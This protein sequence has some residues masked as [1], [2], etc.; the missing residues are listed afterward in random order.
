MLKKPNIQ[1]VKIPTERPLSRPKNFP[2][3]PILYLEL[4]E[5]KAKINPIL[6]NQ[7]YVPKNLPP[8]APLPVI[9]ER[10]EYED[11]KERE[12]YPNL[13]SPP[14]KSGSPSPSP[15]S[16]SSPSSRHSRNSRNSSGNSRHS[17]GRSR[18]SRDSSK[19]SGSPVDK[20]SSRE[21]PSRS[22]DDDDDLSSRM[23]ELM[24]EE[25]RDR[26]DRNDR[27]DRHDRHDRHDKHDK[28]EKREYK[29]ESPVFNYDESTMGSSNILPPRLSEISG[30]NYVK[31]KV[32]EELDT[33]NPDED[34]L[35]RELLFKFELLKRA[36]KNTP[37][38]EFTIHSDYRTMVKS[39]ES[40]I[41]R[42]NVDSNIESYKSYLITGFYIVEFI[43]G[44]W[45]KFD[46]QD[47]TQ[48]QIIG[49][50]KYEHLLIELGEKNYVPEGS[51]WP[52]EI[53]LLFTII[54]QAAIFIITKMVMK[55]VGSGLFGL[56]NMMNMGNN[57]NNNNNLPSQPQEPKRRMRGP[58]IE[59]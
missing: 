43:L 50:N 46:M 11:R 38:E 56:G 6:V 18:H 36:Y 1:V 26:H 5:N 41:R 17:S 29:H 55:K 28:R 3:M 58:D 54:I 59:I 32:I 44:H 40:T 19:R 22:K 20:S 34:D 14:I 7:E 16:P 42:V 10:D 9:Q 12:D 57:N 52:V 15:P 4:L 23:K 30:G 49:M 53:R 8:N 39:Y 48:Q 24:I 33:R 47:F 51:K 21:S 35:K 25:R 2:R 27:N 37:I 45:F 31:N 13:P